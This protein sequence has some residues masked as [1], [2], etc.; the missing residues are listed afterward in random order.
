MKLNDLLIEKLEKY[1]NDDMH[2]NERELF[3]EEINDSVDLQEFIE[4][5]NQIDTFKND[6]D[7]VAFKGDAKKLKQV[8]RLFQKSDTVAFSQKLKDFKS[9]YTDNNSTKKIKWQRIAL[10]SSV[11][12]SI[13]FIFYSILFQTSNLSNIYEQHNSWDEIPSLSVKGNILESQKNKLEKLF[14]S[15]DYNASII[16]CK[17]ILSSSQN[18]EP[19]ILLYLGISQIETGNYNDALRTFSKLINTNTIDS[20][21]GYW[22]KAMVYLKLNDKENTINTLQKIVSNDYYMKNDASIILKEIK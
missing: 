2:H 11:A 16:L 12:A 3:Q 6:T 14:L 20:H 1:L 9:N 17:T 8:T 21:K 7:W 4:I 10:F 15:K 5:Y 18:I 22:Y 13:F 19:N